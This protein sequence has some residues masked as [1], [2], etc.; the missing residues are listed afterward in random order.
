MIKDKFSELAEGVLAH[1]A[2]QVELQDKDYKIELDMLGGI[3]SIKVPAGEYI[4]N[5]HSAAREVWL[6]SPISGPYHFA[7]RD[8]EWKNKKGVL[9]L[10]LLSSELS[11]VTK[12][13]L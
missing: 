1:I 13:E 9:L 12:I 4:I 8:G 6:A 3:M 10:S 7:Y 11:I 2:E 5:K